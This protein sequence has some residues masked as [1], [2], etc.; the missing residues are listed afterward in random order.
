MNRVTRQKLRA[1]HAGAEWGLGFIAGGSRLPAVR[2]LAPWQDLQTA[3]RGKVEEPAE[4]TAQQPRATQRMR[5]SPY[6]TRSSQKATA[7]A[8]ATLSESTPWVM[9]IFTV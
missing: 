8:A 7:L 6:R 3:M 1:G 5:L 2:R 4:K 9:G